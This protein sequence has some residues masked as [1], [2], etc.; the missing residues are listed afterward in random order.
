MKFRLQSILC[1]STPLRLGWLTLVDLMAYCGPAPY[2][3]SCGSPVIAYGIDSDIR[4]HSLRILI[5]YPWTRR[6]VMQLSH[7]KTLS[8]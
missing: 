1:A 6:V 3:Y 2:D 8:A 4:F 7:D 5:R